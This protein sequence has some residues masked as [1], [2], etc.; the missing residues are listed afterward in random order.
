MMPGTIHIFSLLLLITFIGVV[1]QNNPKEDNK[2]SVSEGT[3]GNGKLI[4]GHRIPFKGNN[5]E[6]FSSFSYNI[7]N[8]GYVNGV[9][10]D[11]VLNTYKECESF[12]PD[13]K[14]IIMECSHKTGGRIKP[15]RTH[16]NG[17]SIDFGTPLLKDGKQNFPQSVANLYGYNMDFT[18]EGQMENDQEVHI[19]FELMA[20][21]LFIL[22]QEVGRKG[23]K[24]EKVI[25]KTALHEKLFSTE[26]GKK[27]KGKIYFARKLTPLL[28]KIHD[29]HYHVDFGFVKK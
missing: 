9:V 3:V 21:H 26:Y 24:I 2:R 23:L 14:F 19:D 16:Q 20:K 18:K 7:L 22:N 28:N 11:A 1:A 10:K 12:C 25:F 5:Y 8:R 4:N 6:Y 15:H 13:M 17:L 27:I 29:D